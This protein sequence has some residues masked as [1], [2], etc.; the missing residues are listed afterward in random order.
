MKTNV[1]RVSYEADIFVLALGAA[2]AE[3][4]ALDYLIQSNDADRNLAIVTTTGLHRG[5]KVV[6]MP[7]ATDV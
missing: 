4:V 1:Y 5:T 2:A 6:V 7:D 3:K